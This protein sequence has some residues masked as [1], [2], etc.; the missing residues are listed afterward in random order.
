MVTYLTSLLETA[1]NIEVPYNHSLE[2][3]YKWNNGC[4][5]FRDNIITTW[6]NGSYTQLNSHMFK[7]WWNNH[8]HVIKMNED[9]TK[10]I[11]V[12]TYPADFTVVEGSIM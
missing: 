7:V 3:T 8:Y 10:Y 4:I 1:S 11:S 9:F 5:S 2:K 6:G 12:R